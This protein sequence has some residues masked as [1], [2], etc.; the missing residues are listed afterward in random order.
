MSY[1]QDELRAAWKEQVNMQSKVLPRES[2][3]IK[4]FRDLSFS[5]QSK[6]LASNTVADVIEKR[7]LLSRMEKDRKKYDTKLDRLLYTGSATEIEAGQVDLEKAEERIEGLRR[8]IQQQ[9]NRLGLTGRTQLK[10]FKESEFLQLRV[11]AT[12]LQERIVTQLVEYRFEMS[13]FD[14]LAWYECL[15]RYTG[16]ILRYFD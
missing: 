10:E 7:R 11:N 14:Q 4:I 15:G 9:E 8:S 1:T 5:G 3:N 13:K 12:V 2:G 16:Y 6:K